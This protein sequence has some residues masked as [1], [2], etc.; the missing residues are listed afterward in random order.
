MRKYLVLVCALFLVAMT[1]GYPGLVS[2]EEADV[3]V[4]EA[5]AEETLAEEAGETMAE[6]E[7]AA[8]TVG[9]FVVAEDVVANEPEGATDTFP[10]TAD[11]AYGFLE[12][13]D[14]TEDTEAVIV[15]HREGHE[16]ARVSL[17]LRQGQ[18]WRT[19]SSKNISGLPGEWKVVVEDSNG[20]VLKTAEFSVE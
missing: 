9:R 14:I 20:N 10:A 18:R 19:Y 6:E 7:G 13:T 16:V 12:A 3:D 4:N 17:K 2:A 15:W 8:F 1:A 5:A 11:K